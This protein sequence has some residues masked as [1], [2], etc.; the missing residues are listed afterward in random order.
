MRTQTY[1]R[2]NFLSES[3]I[4]NERVPLQVNCCGAYKETRAFVTHHNRTDYYYLYVLQG[5]LQVG[6]TAV[7]AG[8]AYLFSPDLPYSY[9]NRGELE[10]LWVHFT[11][12]AA[13]KLSAS[14]FGGLDRKIHIGYREDIEKRF[15]RLFREFMIRD[16]QFETLST[17]LLQ[18]ILALTARYTEEKEMPLKSM[19][20]IHRHFSE[21]IAM[22][23]LAD[24][25]NM[26]LTAFRSVFKKHTGVSP[27]T[28]L[29]DL[30]MQAACRFLTDTKESVGDIALK[31]GYSDPYYFSRIFTKKMGVSPLQYRKKSEA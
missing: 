16:G 20:Y 28:Y 3:N 10:Y 18:E 6:E 21:N 1:H 22:E 19:A 27:N 9:E 2:E 30:R 5:T 7:H 12:H 8:E 26:C 23:T 31:V 25:E 24:M 4:K 29:I 15:E 14:V 11:G 13:R 17:C